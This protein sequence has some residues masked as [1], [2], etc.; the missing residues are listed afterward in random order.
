MPRHLLCTNFYF[1]YVPGMKKDGFLTTKVVWMY[2]DQFDEWY[3]SRPC[4]ISYRVIIDFWSQ[5]NAAIL[6]TQSEWIGIGMGNEVLQHVAT[7]V[8]G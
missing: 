1:K 5:A 8:T 7:V 6:N 3:A 2:F 4:N